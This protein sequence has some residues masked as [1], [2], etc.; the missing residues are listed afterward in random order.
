MKKG[1]H[2]EYNEYEVIM[3]TGEK[4]RMR[5]TLKRTEPLKLDI[6]PNTHPAWTGKRNTKDIGGGAADRFNKRF[7]AFGKK[8]AT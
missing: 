2:P 7:S 6:D 1:V 8:S 4:I 3:T 5:S